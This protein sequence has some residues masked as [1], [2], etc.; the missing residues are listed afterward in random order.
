M[1]GE[2]DKEITSFLFVQL[3]LSH[4]F[5]ILAVS[6]LPVTFG[7]SPN[8]RFQKAC[9][10]SFGT[11]MFILFMHLISHNVK[12]IYILN[13]LPYKINWYPKADM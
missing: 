5:C 2:I 8:R 11:L 3:I 10:I 6:T 12:S 13:N 1:N 4:F 7:D 9:P